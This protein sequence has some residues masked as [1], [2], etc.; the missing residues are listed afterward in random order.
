M[1]LT[2]ELVRNLALALDPDRQGEGWPDPVAWDGR[3]LADQARDMLVLADVEEEIGA[4]GAL[5]AVAA[6]VRRVVAS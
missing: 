2:R 5:I 4:S 3:P 6:A 1:S